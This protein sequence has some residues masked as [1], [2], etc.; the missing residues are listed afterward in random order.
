MRKLTA[1]QQT[2]LFKEW[3]E[4]EAAAKQEDAYPRSAV[5]EKEAFKNI[6]DGKSE[7]PAPEKVKDNGLER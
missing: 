3:R 6:L 2:A 5:T 1:K 7:A 4:D